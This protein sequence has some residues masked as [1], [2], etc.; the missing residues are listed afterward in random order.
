MSDLLGSPPARPRPE[1]DQARTLEMLATLFVVVLVVTTLYVGREIFIPIAIAIPVSFVLAPPVLLLRRWGLG[2]VP[3]VLTVVLAALVIAFL[4]SAVLTRQVSELAIDLPKYQATVNAKIVKLRDAAADNALFAK[5]SAA[6]RNLGE[7][8]PQRPATS[9]APA[10]SDQAKNQLTKGQENQPPVPVEVHEPAWGPF[11]IVET[12][13]GTALSSLE[14][15]FIVVIF[16]IFILLQREDLRNRFI[17]LAGSS[18]LHRTTLAMNDAAGRLSRFFLVQ[19]LVNASFGVIVAVGLYFIGVP[20]PILWGVAAFLLRFVPYFGPI[21]A[22][23]FPMALAAAIDPGWGMAL[24]TVALFLFVE[25]II[26]QVV[27]P[28]LYGHNTGTSPVA[29]VISATFWWWMWGTAG[30]VLSTPLT[31]CLVVL[32]RHVER[33]AFLDV[34]FGDAP[35]LTP[36]EN[37]Y[38]R[39]LAGDE[40]EV[41]DQAEQFLKTNS[42]I[43][44]Y[45]EVA[46]QALLMAQVDLRRGV[47]DEPRQRRIKETIDEVIE[48]LSDH[49]DEPAA[50]APA[51]GAAPTNSVLKSA[52]TPPPNE[53]ASGETAPPNIR[54]AGLAPGHESRKPVLCIAGRSFLDEAAAALLAQILEKHGMRATVEPAGA[55]T[56]GRISRLTAEGARLVCLSYLDADLSTAGARLA[57][58]RL[59]RRL[60]EAK[61]LACFWQS[62]PGQASELCAATKADFCATSFKD[63]VAFCIQEAVEEAKAE[64]GKIDAKPAAKTFAG[65]A[66]S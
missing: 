37:F 4:V 24:E 1:P 61:I 53:A 13:A 63:T 32:G 51:P 25:S 52:G 20:S 19:T 27:E 30:L 38:Q 66:E 28:W 43:D 60:P 49:V 16:V 5:V 41:V 59:R 54:R 44:Y 6:L 56:A 48:D 14:T 31:V 40:S 18:D 34:M 45:D 35:P 11:A 39:M 29:V 36:V 26:G 50:S 8:N 17:R 22:A 12:I 10:P 15:A 3:S 64:A 42:L 7:I 47:L 33:L 46:L 58:R 2:R 65:A 62:G 21:I 9:S 57:V 23:G 55:L